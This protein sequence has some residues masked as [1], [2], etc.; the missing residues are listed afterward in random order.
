MGTGRTPHLWQVSDVESAS[1]HNPEFNVF[2]Q[3]WITC[4]GTHTVVSSFT[5]LQDGKYIQ[6]VFRGTRKYVIKACV[7]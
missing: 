4:L 5:G 2:L 6:C 7:E 1:V 3:Q